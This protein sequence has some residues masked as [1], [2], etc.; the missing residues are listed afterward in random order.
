MSKETRRQVLEEPFGVTPERMFEVL[1]S[2]TAIRSWWGAT[3]V[4]IDPR[5][6]G[7]WVTATG[8][9]HKKAEWVNSFSIKEYD[10]PN[11]MLL[12]AGKYFAGNNWPIETNMTTEFLVQPQPTGCI[13]TIIQELSPADPLLDDFFEA[14]VAGWQNSFEGIRNYLHNNPTD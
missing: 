1:T 7:S 12:G 11:R 3:S 10:P 14:C 4:V 9:E 13:L 8:D 5:K 6:G 2:P